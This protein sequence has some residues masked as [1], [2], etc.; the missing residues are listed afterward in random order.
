MG[1]LSVHF[2]HLIHRHEE[3]DIAR[4]YGT[5]THIKKLTG[6]ITEAEIVPV[7]YTV[8]RDGHFSVAGELDGGSIDVLG[9]AE[10]HSEI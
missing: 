7:Y 3:E 10:D 9:T 4:L 2:Q 6:R 8:W 5:S 1:Y